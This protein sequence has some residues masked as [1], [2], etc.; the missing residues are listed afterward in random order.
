R[1]M[2]DPYVV[3]HK[4]RSVLCAPFVNQ[5]KLVAIVYLEN[6]LTDGA[7]TADRLEVLRLLSAH[8]ALSIH[9]AVLYAKLEDYN[10]TLEQK[11]DERTRELQA[12]NEELGRTLRQL[13]SMQKQLVTQEKLASLGALTAGITHE[14]QNPLNFVNNF[15]EL[16]TGLVDE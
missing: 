6:N 3:R 2:M 5:G 12:T 9:N 1:F 15:A 11:V 14:I 16:S 4:P 7:F 10:R 8:A 13:R